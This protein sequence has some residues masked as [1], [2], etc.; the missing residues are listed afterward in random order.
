MKIETGEIAKQADGA[1]MVTFGD[2]VVFAAAVRSNPRPHLDFFPLQIDYR[3]K[4]TAMGK[5]PGGFFKREGRPSNKEILTMRMIDRPSRPL[6][7][8]GYKDDL[9]VYV[10]VHSCDEENNPD[11]VGMVA[12]SAALSV[13]P[14]PF[15][16]PTGSVRVGRVNGEFVTNPTPA[17]LDESDLELVVAGTADNITMVEAG[18]DG[19][20]ESDMLDALNYGHGVIKEIC[21]M[22]VE[23]QGKFGTVKTEWTAP[24]LQWPSLKD[25]IKK[26]H[27]AGLLDA[28]QTPA[29]FERRDAIS[30]W[31][32]SV[33][34]AFAK[35]DLE[36]DE[37]KAYNKELSEALY[38]LTGEGFR[39]LIAEGKR[40]DGRKLDEIRPIST[41]VGLFPRVHGSALFTRGETQAIISTTLGS[42]DDEQRIDGLFSE[43]REKFMLHY[44]FPSY[45]V[46]ETKPIRGPGRREIGH[47]ALAQ[48]ALQPALPDYEEFPYTVRVVSDITE[49]NGSSSMASVCGGSMAM[50][51]AGV[52]LRAPVAGIAMG[53]VM[54]GDT[55]CILSD[56]LGDEDHYGEMDFKVCGTDQGITALQMDI[57]SSGV[58]A[59]LMTNAL[60]QARVGRIHILGEMAKTISEPGPMSQYAPRHTIV[61]I[62]PEKIGLIIGPGG[63]NIRKIQEE[64]ECEIDIDDDGRVVIS[65]F[66]PEGSER[67]KAIIE[68]MTTSPTVGT[69]YKGKVVSMKD[70]GCFVEFLPGQEG[71]VHVSELSTDYVENVADVVKMGDEIDVKVIF[72]DDTGR[73]KLSRR[74][75]LDPDGSQSAPRPERGDGGGRGGDRGG[76]GRG[77][78][79]GGDRGGRDR[80]RGGRGGRGGRD[81]ERGGRGGR[82]RNSDDAPKGETS[83]GEPKASAPAA[84]EPGLPGV[85]EGKASEAGGDAGLEGFGQVKPI[86][87]TA[88]AV[89]GE[90]GNGGGGDDAEGD[91]GGDKKRRRRRGGRGR[92]RRRKEGGEEASGGDGDG[93]APAEAS[94]DAPAEAPPAF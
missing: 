26:D 21:A 58:S 50:L 73:V 87:E 81:R 35:D 22:I 29:K 64:T 19:I 61:M 20:S 25:D 90:A 89:T 48:R 44:N 42:V 59:E 47:G 12:A 77:G 5:F 6:F 17:Q 15:Q 8:D 55:P 39:Q 41:R 86:G 23:L 62:N 31:K 88:A 51:H 9:Q 16:G 67:C 78:D 68:G 75:V 93:A 7:P 27:Y 36:G 18:A 13:S 46:G 24:E 71:L 2:T 74:A 49:S 1:V 38:G 30:A 65:S 60:E 4:L 34:E 63:K 91:G 43:Y 57:K 33:K 79:R 11:V 82:D 70:F 3:E 69:V 32:T 10:V 28:I 83:E 76:R 56:I 66:N 14:L 92:G 85:P 45:S 84:E 54:H 94:D 37:L 72:I 53:L 80:D 40:A 52:P